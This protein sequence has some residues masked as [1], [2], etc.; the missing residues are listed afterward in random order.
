L[1]RCLLEQIQP[2]LDRALEHGDCAR[3]FGAGTQAR[4]LLDELISGNSSVGT[5]VF[6]DTPFSSGADAETRKNHPILN[7]FFI[8][9]T[10]TVTI[11]S[12]TFSPTAFNTSPYNAAILVL[13]EFG[14]VLYYLGYAS[15]IAPDQTSASVS[16][17]NRQRVI[18]ACGQYL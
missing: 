5:I 6:T 13:H 12:G 9:T 17:A 3:I 4:A 2:I 11:Y 18:D 15:M 14:H 1:N 16:E 10:S 7:F 8:P